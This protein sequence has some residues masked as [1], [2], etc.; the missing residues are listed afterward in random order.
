[1][2]KFSWFVRRLAGLRKL[3]FRP[4]EDGVLRGGIRCFAPRKACFCA[5]KGGVLANYR[6]AVAPW[7]MKI[8]GLIGVF[9]L[10]RFL[11]RGFLLSK[12]LNFAD[13]CLCTAVY[14]Y[15]SSGRAVGRAA[16]GCGRSG[17][18][19]RPC[20]GG[21]SRAHMGWIRAFAA[22]LAV[23][24]RS[25]PHAAAPFLRPFLRPKLR[26]GWDFVAK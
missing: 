20:G 1:M 9:P 10:R 5:A 4:A 24:R 16:R 3:T 11:F 17:C 13:A 23:R 12:F 19:A 2:N 8:G 25:L 14:K 21:A 26:C 15:A 18:H 7:M 6:H 22:G